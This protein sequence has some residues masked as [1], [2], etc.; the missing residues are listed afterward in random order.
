MDVY[1]QDGEGEDF[2]QIT[3]IVNTKSSWA[4][5]QAANWVLFSPQCP[6]LRKECL[7]VSATWEAERSISM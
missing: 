7:S 2:C 4:G 5:T 6:K 1:A 3:V